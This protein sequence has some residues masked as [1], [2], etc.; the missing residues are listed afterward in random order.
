M[1]MEMVSYDVPNN[2]M[3]E[4]SLKIE[5]YLIV[6]NRLK[7]YLQARSFESLLCVYFEDLT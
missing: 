7:I 5:D 6:I 3:V 2:Q 4:Y 1:A